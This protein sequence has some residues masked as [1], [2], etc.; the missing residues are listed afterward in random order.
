MTN[1]AETDGQV[2]VATRETLVAAAGGAGG[3]GAL[4]Q[5]RAFF[6]RRRTF[7]GIVVAFA[8]VVVAEPLPV[9]LFAGMGVMAIAHTLRLVCAGYLD[10]DATLVTSE[11]FGWC[12]NPLYIANFL[13]V[14]AFGLMSG[15][16]VMLPILLVLS[17]AAHAP[18]VAGEEEF[19][20]RKF[21]EEFDRYCERVPRWWPKRPTRP[22]EG[23]FRWAR[24]VANG[25]HLNIIS[26]WLMAAMFV[27][28]MVR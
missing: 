25:E 18:T 21:G 2:K 19:L 11:P 22:D 4:A 17:L 28:E 26:V 14:V 27:I 10:K 7:L 20:R 23:G 24:V 12:R 9:L 16:L 13:V 15:R 5:V 1:Y 6:V 8:L 3:E